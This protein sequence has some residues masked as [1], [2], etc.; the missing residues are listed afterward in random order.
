MVGGE[1]V[2]HMNGNN[3]SAPRFDPKSTQKTLADYVA[4][5]KKSAK[6]HPELKIVLK[7]NTNEYQPKAKSISV[8]PQDMHN[9][10]VDYWC[11]S[12][13]NDVK[14]KFQTRHRDTYSSDDSICTGATKR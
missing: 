12:I 1:Y 11:E 8:S 9:Q 14:R 2:L 5:N 6:A 3:M 13:G 10:S 4:G 7:W